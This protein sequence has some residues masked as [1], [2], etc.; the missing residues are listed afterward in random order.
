MPSVQQLLTKDYKKILVFTLSVCSCQE[1][2][3]SFFFVGSTSWNLVNIE[4]ITAGLEMTSLPTEAGT[5]ILVTR[6]S[7]SLWYARLLGQQDV[8][9]KHDKLVCLKQEIF[10]GIFQRMKSF[11][12]K[13][14]NEKERLV[15]VEFCLWKETML[16]TDFIWL[17]EYEYV[18]K[19]LKNEKSIDYVP[20]I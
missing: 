11:F 4:W 9:V 8:M 19:E 13:E 3:D 1:G 20:F 18:Y 16:V 14:N 10:S 15:R 12:F 5:L 7:I 2:N 17:N 6:I